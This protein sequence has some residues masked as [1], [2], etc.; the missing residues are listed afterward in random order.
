MQRTAIKLI[1]QN[2]TAHPG[3]FFVLLLAV[4][5]GLSSISCDEKYREV[6]RGTLQVYVDESLVK[7]VKETADSFMTLYRDAKIEVTGVKSREGITKILNGETAIFV[8]ARNL[9]DEE[10]AFKVKN[11]LDMKTIK[12]VYD[13]VVCIVHADNALENMSY[14]SLA[15]ILSGKVKRI[16]ACVPERNSG[17]TEFLNVHVLHPDDSLAAMRV[18]SEADVIT[19]IENKDA[20]LGFIGWN[21]FPVNRKLHYIRI[22]TIKQG[23]ASSV[24]YE[25]HPGYFVQKLYPL[26]RE[27]VIFLSEVRLGLASGFATFLAAN[28]GQRIALQNNLGPATVPVRL[29][30]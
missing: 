2:I 11:P 14:D 7:T 17:I 24:Y 8:S 18:Q 30:Q 5:L 19:A 23:G 3:Y 13:G 12:Y 22:G 29:V 1:Q 4:S 25:P 26:T 20:S 9:N 27:C 28:P 10:K 21:N 6:T 15:L 16:T